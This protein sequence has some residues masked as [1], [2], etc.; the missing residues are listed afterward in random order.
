MHVDD[1]LDG[2]V[3]HVEGEAVAAE[4]LQQLD[5]VQRVGHGRGVPQGEVRGREVARTIEADDGGQAH[6]IRQVA[7]VVDLGELG[8]QKSVPVAC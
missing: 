4:S 6:A 8:L 5:V 7:D 1:V 2:Q 3:A